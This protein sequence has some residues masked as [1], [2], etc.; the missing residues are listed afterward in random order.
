MRKTREIKKVVLYLRYSSDRQQETSIEGQDEVCTRFCAFNGYEI[1]GKYI[2]RAVSARKNVEKRVRFLQMMDDAKQDKFDAIVVYK[3]DRFSRDQYTSA[4][5]TKLLTELDIAILSA[6]ENLN[7]LAND[8]GMSSFMVGIMNAFAV[9]YSDE[10]S[11]KVQRGMKITAQKCQYNGGAVPLGFKI[12]DKRYVIDE[13]KAEYVRSIFSDYVGGVE[14]KTIIDKAAERGIKLTKQGLSHLLANEK[15]IGVYKYD[16]IRVEGGIPAIVDENTFLL[17]KARLENNKN[18]PR[19]RTDGKGN[20]YLLSGKIFCGH[21]GSRMIG[22]SAKG[23]DGRPYYYYECKE[24]I[25]GGCPKKRVKKDAIEN[26]VVEE[27]RKIY[28][29]DEI[30]KIFVRTFKRVFSKIMRG[31]VSESDLMKAEIDKL[32]KEMD[33]MLDSVMKNPDLGKVFTQKILDHDRQIDELKAKLAIHEEKL[34]SV[35]ITEKDVQDYLDSIFLSSSDE[36]IVRSSIIDCMINRVEVENGGKVGVLFNVIRTGVLEQIEKT[37]DD[38][39]ISPILGN[40]GSFKLTVVDRN[41]DKTKQYS[42]VYPMF[43]HLL[44]SA[45]KL[46]GIREV[47]RK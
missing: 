28:L 27:A 10:L 14:M 3:M 11:Q 17:A 13:E 29:D 39:S 12:V 16:E 45:K 7:T 34:K 15:Y 22:V 30:K 41:K 31:T 18:G 1:V 25:G 8:G 2:D 46:M 4:L 26:L 6:S 43:L 5:Y 35:E 32:Q 23:R 38:S 9:Y 20:R 47:R 21:C 40:P 24:S 37:T 36:E 33:S 19:K 42:F 44:V